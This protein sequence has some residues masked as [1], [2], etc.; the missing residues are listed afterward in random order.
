MNL[1]VIRDAYPDILGFTGADFTYDGPTLFVRGGRSR[2]I[3]DSDWPAIV[4]LF[5]QASLRTIPDAGHW[6]HAE[7]PRAFFET[8][9][10]FLTRD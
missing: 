2:Y 8:V 10:A 5:P 9:N 3:E 4:A 6:L 7:Q 1:P